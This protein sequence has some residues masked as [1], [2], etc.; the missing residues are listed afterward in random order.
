MLGLA[1]H[2]AHFYISREEVLFG[3]KSREEQETRQ[4]ESGF[5]EAQRALDESV[6]PVAMQMI[7]NQQKPL[8]RLSIPI[9]RE[10]IAFEFDDT[11][12]NLPF[13]PNLERLIDDIVFLCFFVGNDFLPHLPSLDI[14]VGALDFLFNVYQKVLPTLGDYITSSGGNVNLSKVDVIIR[15]VA[16]IEDHVFMMKHDNEQREKNRRMHMQRNNKPRAEKPPPVRQGRAARILAGNDAVKPVNH[17]KQKTI[18]V[19]HKKDNDAAAEALR[20]SLSG[21]KRK[22]APEPSSED[23]IM[24]DAKDTSDVPSNGKA[25]SKR[26]TKDP[27]SNDSAKKGPAEVGDMEE[28]F[29]VDDDDDNDENDDAKDPEIPKVE[30]IIK[31]QDPE[32]AKKFKEKVKAIQQKKLDEYADNVED[33]VRLHEA[34]WKDR[35]YTDKCKADDVRNHGGREHLFRSYVMGL[36]WVMKYYYDGCPSWKW[37]YPFHYAPFASDLKNVDRF[38][39]DCRSFELST[40]FNPVE[41]LMAVLPSD[42]VH[43]VPKAARWLMTNPESPIIDFYPIDVPVDPN[44]KAMPWLWV[45]LLPFIDEERL[46]AAF[47]PTMAKWTKSELFCNARGLDDGYLYIHQSNQLSKKFAMVLK[48]GC[49]AKDT[50]TRLTDAA[51]YGCPGFSGRI[52]PPLT[53]EL[54]PV[55]DTSPIKLPESAERVE[56]PD[57]VFD[58]DVQANQAVCVAFTE[59]PKLSHKSILLPGVEVPPPALK[60]MDKVIRRP[61]LSRGGGTIANLGSANNHSH[62]SGYGSMNISS[63]ERNL[64]HQNGRG[65]EMYQTGNRTWGSME[66]MPKRRNVPQRGANQWQHNNNNQAHGQHYPPQQVNRQYQNAAY[67]GQQQGYAPPPPPPRNMPTNQPQRRN[68]GPPH[69][70]NQPPQQLRQGGGYSRGGRGPPP[71]QQGGH[72]FRSYNQGQRPHYGGRGQNQDQRSRA[73]V[74]VMNNLRAQLTSTLNR[75]RPQNNGNRR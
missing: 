75:N 24:S 56:A 53:N 63:Y 21:S 3:R 74:D 11:L 30:D 15:E 51:V 7:V 67:G 60:P 13:P 32:V 68:Q 10:Y 28:E 71:Q 26:A 18:Q 34:G 61:K 36:C 6:G 16:A 22:A 49:S 5:T 35:Y 72:D 66:P 40:P 39:A 57:N 47:S 17:R 50:K 19:S 14:R 70:Q 73:S 2:E 55:V 62:K 48:D 31:V 29:D 27:S 38:S 8:Q 12:Q 4:K 37:Y 23:V 25:S 42:S 45:V 1:T 65:H 41:Q 64:A 59:P 20:K 33:K 43:A 9:L 69:P 44:G 46:L 54:R 52:R 58:H